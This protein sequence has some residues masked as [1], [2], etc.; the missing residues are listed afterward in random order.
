MAI[1]FLSS[2]GFSENPFTST[3][4]DREP[5][6]AKYF[7]PPPYFASVR[8]DPADPTSNVIL[9]PRGG[10]KTAQKVMLEEFTQTEA[11]SPVFCV[12]YDSFRPV[13]RSRMSAVTLEWHLIQ[14]VQRTIAGIITLI[15][16]GH[17][18]N[19]SASD[20]RVLSYAFRRFLGD[21]SAADAEQSFSAVKSIPDKITSF[22]SRHRN[23]IVAVVSAIATGWGFSKI[24]IDSAEAELREEPVS[25][26]M[27]R[28]VDIIRSFGFSSVYI[29]I[30]RVD[31]VPE[32]GNDSDLSFRFIEPIL[33]SLHVLEMNNVA[34]K[35]FLWDKTE[36]ALSSSTFRRDRI[37]VHSLNWSQSEL[38]DMLSKRIRA[39]SANSVSSVNDLIEDDN[40]LDLHRLVCLLS[41]GS[42]RDVIRLV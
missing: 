37:P 28:L 11:R 40:H 5:D 10:G 4:A 9:A 18:A 25:Y 30:D 14:I 26:L 20:K 42:P 19:L 6:L 32:L 3:N 33:T 27:A 24:D 39:F 21:L 35:V 29:L 16:S 34:F 2:F 15:E 38:E 12:T 13:N 8:G 17:G 7:V 22:L 23:N 31:E 41:R 1:K 36:D